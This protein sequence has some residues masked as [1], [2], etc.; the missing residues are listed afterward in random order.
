[1]DTVCAAFIAHSSDP[2]WPRLAPPPRSNLPLAD[3]YAQLAVLVAPHL[4]KMP[5]LLTD[6]QLL[7]ECLVHRAVEAE[8]VEAAGADAAQG[9]AVAAAAAA[10]GGRGTA[11]G[12]DGAGTAG[13]GGDG[14]ERVGEGEGEGEGELLRGTEAAGAGGLLYKRTSSGNR[15]AGSKGVCGLWRRCVSLVVTPPSSPL[16]RVRTSHPCSPC[17]PLALALPP[18]PPIAPLANRSGGPDSGHGPPVRSPSR[19][20]R[21][22]RRAG[23]G[24]GGG[25]GCRCRGGGGPPRSVGDGRWRWRWR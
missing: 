7:A 10:A 24:V 17:A 3:V 6:Q 9:R 23:V 25:A 14:G 22:G 2:A 1:M 11:G 13:S 20:G 12:A 5:P 16:H 8:A 21:G 4:A 19:R 18:R 15:S